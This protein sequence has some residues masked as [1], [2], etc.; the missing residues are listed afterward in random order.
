[1]LCV[2]QFDTFH[3]ARNFCQFM[4]EP[5]PLRYRERAGEG[6][7]DHPRWN[8]NVIKPSYIGH[9]GYADSRQYRKNAPKCATGQRVSHGAPN[10]YSFG[11]GGNPTRFSRRPCAFF[12]AH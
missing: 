8:S 9:A 6:S 10:V 4:C 2:I 5:F 11:R 7:D 1:M 12:K 3:D